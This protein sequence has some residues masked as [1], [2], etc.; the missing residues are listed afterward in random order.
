[1]MHK[2]RRNR[3]ERRLMLDGGG[4]TGLGSTSRSDSNGPKRISEKIA[5]AGRHVFVTAMAGLRTRSAEPRLVDPRAALQKLPKGLRENP[6]GQIEVPLP[7]K[8]GAWDEVFRD[9]T[10]VLQ[11]GSV[12]IIGRG[13]LYPI[14]PSGDDNAGVQE[15]ARAA[16]IEDLGRAIREELLAQGQGL[17][18][19]GRKKPV[20]WRRNTFG[21]DTD[22]KDAPLDKVD[23]GMMRELALA[24][25][26]HVSVGPGVQVALARGLPPTLWQPSF[27]VCVG[28]GQ[29]RVLTFAFIGEP[30][31]GDRPDRKRTPFCLRIATGNLVEGAAAVVKGKER[32]V[33]DRVWYSAEAV[34]D[35][36]QT[37]LDV[38]V[39]LEEELF[40]AIQ[41]GCWSDLIAEADSP[42]VRGGVTTEV[43]EA[44][45]AAAERCG[46]AS[47]SAPRL[48]PPRLPP[49]HL[50]FSPARSE[51][52]T[53]SAEIHGVVGNA[54]I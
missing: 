7:Q 54:G 44:S 4:Y 31:F 2:A 43:A 25:A 15:E 10:R 19:K 11:G 3:H 13:R 23:P 35:T 34:Q 48:L 32:A 53:T 46:Q 20:L 50:R 30:V 8:D 21:S 27:A 52:S 28:D 36:V 40:G 18:S 41:D 38:I 49:T 39:G 29:V 16:A 12:F 47:H 51:A 14:R 22:I 37:T 5:L 17:S 24:V 9:F 1:M 26:S 45:E 42:A 6:H 33:S